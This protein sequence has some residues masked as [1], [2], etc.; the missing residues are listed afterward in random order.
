MVTDRTKE[1]YADEEKCTW[2]PLIK[3]YDLTQKNTKSGRNMF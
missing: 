2:Y 3:Q 1:K